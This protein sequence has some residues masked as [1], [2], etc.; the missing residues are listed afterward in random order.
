MDVINYI[1]NASRGMSL[2]PPGARVYKDECMYSFDT[3]DNNAAGLDVCMSCYM[4][5]SRTPFAD[6]TADHYRDKRHALFLNIVRTL[7]PEL[8]RQA[9]AEPDPGSPSPKMPRLEIVE[10]KDLDLYNA[11]YGVYVAPEQLTVPL[12][13][14][15]D[16]V[17]GVARAL[18]AANSAATND[19]IKAWEHEV[20]LCEHSADI[21]QTPAHVDLSHCAL[22]DL[23]E[24]LWICLSCGTI[25]C[26]REQFGSSLKGNSHALSHYDATGHAVAVKLGSLSADET[27]C[28]CYCYKCN[29]E[30]KVPDLAAKLLSFGVDLRSAV[31]SEKTLIELNIDTNKSWQFA[32]DG[33]DGA[34]FPPVFGPG[35]TGLQ[36]LGNSCYLNSVLQALFSI[37]E[38][39]AYFLNLQFD[40]SVPN[41][42][43]DLPSQMIK[44]HHGLLS[45]Q[46]SKP[47]SLK[48]DGYQT[49]I[50]PAAFK[51]LVGADHEEFKTNKQQD[52]NEFLLY[53][54]DKLDRQFGLQLNKSFKFLMGS[55]VLCTECLHGT[56]SQQLLDNLSLPV[57]CKVIGTN[58]A[59]NIYE[60]T[61]LEDMF[62]AFFSKEFIENYHCEKCGIPTLASKQE[63]FRTFPKNLIV[64]AQRI[65]LENWVPVKQEVPVAVP[66]TI[67]LSEF[68]A[69]D[70]SRDEMEIHKPAPAE[71]NTKF[72][73]N[74]EALS[75]LL[76]MGFSEPR[77]ARGLYNTGNKS[78]EDA[79]NWV[80]AHMEDADIDAPF[81]ATKEANNSQDSVPSEAIDN[82]VSM[83]FSTQLAK[84]ALFVNKNDVNASVEWLFNNP[85]DDGV[86]E[87]LSVPAVNLAKESKELEE[88][89][90]RSALTPATPVYSIKAVVCHK[91]SSPHTGHYVVFI[92]I[93]GKWHLFNDEKVVLCGDN[94]DDMKK[95]GYIY[96]LQRT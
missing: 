26:G 67:N 20:F 19:D 38:Y 54:F 13:Q 50:K 43:L 25:G 18:L 27:S 59:G 44:L 29:E 2:V 22:C 82:L 85:D 16:N 79:M 12:D 32:L 3:A 89:L 91:G 61:S 62:K 49:G 96:F 5:Y 94:V 33:A 66:E 69:P 95:T 45:G 7:K 55:K 57:P 42:A 34:Q 92:K 28:D 51:A 40:K 35:F 24:N 74:P 87:E 30:V 80:F 84:K 93:D 17:Q 78:A 65:T 72:E 31:K 58:D 37:D 9:L 10:H 77:S 52:A 1:A 14:C 21:V 36:N 39:R 83:G 86:I 76:S 70:F 90:T 15:P 81:D 47:S 6:F 23:A 4:A 88:E 63:G 60:E 68:V 75:M 71:E 73:P 64:S 53:L 46:Y 41:A 11:S 8:E 56:A 48:G